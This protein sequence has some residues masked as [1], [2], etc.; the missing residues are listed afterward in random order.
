MKKLFIVL[1]GLDGAGTSTQATLLKDYFV[2][3]QERAVISPE[4]SPGPIGKLIREIMQD[5]A[6]LSQNQP[7]FDLQMSYLFAADRHYHLYNQVDGVLKTI[8][9][10][11]CHVITPRYYFSSLAYN[12]HNSEQLECIYQLNHKFPNPDLVIYIDVPLE[13]SLKR[14]KERAIREVYENQENLQRVREN[15][16]KIFQ[17]YRG[18]ILV[19]KGTYSPQKVNQIIVN[20]INDFRKRLD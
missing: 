11:L 4:P 12:A 7:V 8:N 13:V 5:P 16:Q 3:R 2:G 6:I 17:N 10:D 18:E 20:Y 9:Q 14:L 19:V 15:Y 1:E